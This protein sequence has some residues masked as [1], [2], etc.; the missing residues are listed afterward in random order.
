[1][2]KWTLL[3][4]TPIPFLYFIFPTL[5][6]VWYISIMSGVSF[7]IIVNV[8]K[9]IIPWLHSKPI[10]FDD[11]E[12][13]M[14]PQYRDRFQQWFT[15]ILQIMTSLICIALVWYYTQ[16]YESTSLSALELLGVLGG[17]LSLMSKV[18]DYTG[19]FLLMGLNHYRRINSPFIGPF[20]GDRLDID[21][22]SLGRKDSD[23]L[24]SPL[25]ILRT[26]EPIKTN[27]IIDLNSS[28]K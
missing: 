10:Y 17:F 27:S 5:H 12:D 24:Q 15:R 13:H 9:C 1:M 6:S 22:I 18:E 4:L 7:Y 21:G 25:G 19:S 23:D 28:E 26:T 8:F 11:L 20:T 16:R 3:V 2:K 14:N